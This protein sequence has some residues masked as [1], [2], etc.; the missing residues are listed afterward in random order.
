M[1]EQNVLAGDITVLEEIIQNINEHNSTIEKRGNLSDTAKTLSKNIEAVEKNIKNEID[2]KLKEGIAS[3][4]SGYDKSISEEQK[5]LKEVQGQRDRAKIA[6]MRKRIEQETTELRDNNEELN[7]KIR[8]LC[9]QEGIPSFCS[10]KIFLS[11]FCGKGF[12]DGLW[13]FA[14]L[15]VFYLIIPGILCF[16]NIISKY[17]FVIYDFLFIVLQSFL[18]KYI[19]LNIVMPHLGTLIQLRDLNAE[20]ADNNKQIKRIENEIK[21]DKNEEMYGLDSYDSKIQEVNQN[22]ADIENRKVTAIKDFETFTKSNIIM[23]VENQYRNKRDSLTKDLTKTNTEMEQID[24]MIKEQRANLSTNYEP[25]LGKEF[26]NVKKLEELVHIMKSGKAETI[27]NAIS[28]YR[29][30]S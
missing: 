20:I 12:I 2:M 27:S 24:S 22:I 15:L 1:T 16:L 28:V 13:Y 4:S 10:N 29:E 5:K 11:V 18:F 26:M 30:A 17:T 3:V 7:N 8:N 14:V 9:Q 6:G 21:A 25:Y 23:E 19:Y